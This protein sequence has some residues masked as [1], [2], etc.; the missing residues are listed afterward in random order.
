MAKKAGYTTANNTS[1]LAIPM[2]AVNDD[3]GY[4][5]ICLDDNG[6]SPAI[7]L[8]RKASNTWERLIPV[9]YTVSDSIVATP[10]NSGSITNLFSWIVQKIKAITGKA[11]WTDAPAI[12]LE[13]ANKAIASKLNS[14]SYTS[15]DVLSKLLTVDGA[16]SGI[17]ADLLDGQHGAFYAPI[18]NTALTGTPT[19]PTAALNTGTVQIANCLFVLNQIAAQIAALVNSSPATLDTLNEIATALG[20]DPNFSTTII[21]ALAG[22]EPSIPSGTSSKYWRGDKSWQ[23]LDNNAIGLS[24][25]T[26]HLQVNTTTTQD[27]SGD[28]YFLDSLLIGVNSSLTVQPYSNSDIKS[29]NSLQVINSINNTI[30]FS[31]N[32]SG[33]FVFLN[34]DVEINTANTTAISN[35]IIGGHT[36]VRNYGSGLLTN[37]QGLRLT[38]LNSGTGNITTL[39]GAAFTARN[40]V[41]ATVTTLNGGNFAA[42]I[43]NI[44]GTATT[45]NGGLFTV[46]A[47]AASFCTTVRGISIVASSSNTVAA[48]SCIGI[49][50]GDITGTAT[51]KYALKTGVGKVYIGDTTA[52]TNSTSGAL[53]VAGDIGVAGSIYAG[54]DVHG[55]NIWLLE[56]RSST[57]IIDA[58]SLVYNQFAGTKWLDGS[59]TNLNVPTNSGMLHQ[60][61]S[62][63]GTGTAAKYRVQEYL[64]ASSGSNAR[65]WKRTESN[66]TW[67]SWLE[68]AFLEKANTWTGIQNFTT[69]INIGGIKVVGARDT[70][71][72]A[73]TGTATKTTFATSTVTLSQLAERVKALIDAGIASGSIGA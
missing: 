58:N 20:N 67:G 2:D 12:T 13:D 47:G 55:D 71:W 10:V 28:K 65:F 8:W 27:I 33:T 46:S 43:G 18:N 3:D 35:Q 23:T 52:A 22:K 64:L 70:G 38:A 29:I 30:T 66:N 5:K 34:T 59:V 61:D 19:A 68:I 9:S 4:L 40:D 69:Q 57:T 72:A 36:R 41:A 44:A 51:N 73:A 25:L 7:F 31:T 24:N 11:S 45:I 37:M 15:S 6:S 62:L 42:S 48:T 32:P 1:L 49:E 16:T 56:P 26:N 53:I 50:I 54:G 17:D 60:F 21:N 39:D 63:F 14:S